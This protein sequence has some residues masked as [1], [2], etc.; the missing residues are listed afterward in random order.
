MKN[1]S[2]VNRASLTAILILLPSFFIQGETKA[3]VLSYYELP[4]NL[5]FYARDE[6]DSAFV[7]Y[8]GLLSTSG[9]DSVYIE[10][11]RNN[12]LWKRKSNKLNY[13][14]GS[15]AFSIGQNIY[16]ELAE[17]KFRLYIK[18]GSTSTLM[19]TADSLVC[20]D[21]YLVAGQSNS[22]PTSSYATYKN[23]FCRSFGVQTANYNGNNYNPADTAWGLS[24]ADGSVYYFSGPYNVGVWALKLQEMIRNTYGIPTCFINGGRASTTISMN[25]KN[26]S[27]PTDL[28]SVYGKLLYRV[29]KSGLASKVKAIFWY[30][31]ESDG[32]TA[33][34]NYLSSF[35]TLYNTWKSDYPNFEKVFLFQTR[36][37][38]SEQY[39]SQLREVQRKLPDEFPNI[40]LISTAGI[41]YYEG[42]HFGYYGYLELAN[43]VLRP[44]SYYFY[45]GTD[46]LNMRPPNIKAAFFTTPSKN[47][48][49]VLFSNSNAASWPADTL[50]QRMKDY[51][52]LDGQ[53]GKVQQGSVSGDT[54]K[55]KL[56]AASTA[57]K[58]SYLPTVWNHDDSLVYEGPFIKNSRRVG[59]LSFH[60]YPIG[61]YNT[62][63][64]NLT[65]VV[66]GYYSQSSNKLSIRDTLRV[67]VRRNYYPYQIIDSCRSVIDSVT[68][69]GS[70]AF[71][72][73]PAGT[74]YIVV[75]GVSILETWCKSP[76][77]QLIPGGTVD[78]NFSTS[79]S[80]AYG[81][82]LI[83]KGSRA[84]IYSSDVNADGIIDGMDNA[85]VSNDA[86]NQLLG[87]LPTDVNGDRFVDGSDVIIVD[88]NSGNYIV[89]RTP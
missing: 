40:E 62:A 63:R 42:C 26:A 31:G 36:P 11:Y 9:Y 68:F 77:I 39:A 16:C 30:Q 6:D 34:T 53:T 25:L 79:V 88:Q 67:Y 1:I 61:A 27:N 33:W 7:R 81:N 78:F 54:L 19:N 51:F 56:Y 86:F 70:Y 64:L 5:Q 46:T 14:S 73:V 24:R 58:L 84:C 89:K 45:G 37:C 43:I 50:N 72:N 80:Q 32:T 69:K 8:S 49:A 60:D 21:V 3:A 59:V 66:E 47:E 41:P 15:A 10:V 17:Y 55:L 35:R 82:N 20:G 12:V 85:R 57:T 74:Y 48:I 71:T 87:P 65:A 52:Y 38:C 4:R 76:G 18:A 44:F 29:Q 83:M 13:T 2:L 75:K 28:S 22:H 23:E